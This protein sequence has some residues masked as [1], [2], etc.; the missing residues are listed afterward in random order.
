M[1]NFICYS[2]LGLV[3]STCFALPPLPPQTTIKVTVKQTSDTSKPTPPKK[4]Y[5]TTDKYEFSPALSKGAD[6]A[7][8]EAKYRLIIVLKESKTIH[9]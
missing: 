9:H 8:T 7:N 2:L 3:T 1:K 5:G 6:L 4:C